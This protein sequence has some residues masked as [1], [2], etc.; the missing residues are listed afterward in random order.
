MLDVAAVN[1]THATDVPTLAGL[2]V[3]VTPVLPAPVNLETGI[4]QEGPRP[5]LSGLDLIW[6]G[7]RDHAQRRRAKPASIRG[8]LT[9]VRGPSASGPTGKR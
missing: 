4:R 1:A 6:T 5:D 7:L 2:T 8:H 3:A 9:V